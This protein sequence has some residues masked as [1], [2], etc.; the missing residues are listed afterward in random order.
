[1]IKYKIDNVSKD[2]DKYVVYVKLFDDQAPDIILA[3]LSIPFETQETFEAALEAKTDKYLLSVMNIEAIK[4]LVESSI[5]KIES[6]ITD[7]E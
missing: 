5:I 4:T 6:I 2:A 7:K 1:M 3:N